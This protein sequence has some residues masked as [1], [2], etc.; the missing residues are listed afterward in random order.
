LSLEATQC[1]LQMGRKNCLVY[2]KTTT[3]RWE[4]N[5][6]LQQ[7]MTPRTNAV[8]F[9]AV[10]ANSGTH[11]LQEQR[12]LSRWFANCLTASSTCC[13]T[14]KSPNL[15]L[16]HIYGFGGSA[17]SVVTLTSARWLAGR[18]QAAMWREPC[19][20]DILQAHLLYADDRVLNWLASSIRLDLSQT[21]IATCHPGYIGSCRQS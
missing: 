16:C 18:G 4:S 6:K 11:S 17:Q 7:C 1:N 2:Y 21:L 10:I 9:A 15:P 5:G 14:L 12:L 13:H 3:V 19:L 20:W 8:I